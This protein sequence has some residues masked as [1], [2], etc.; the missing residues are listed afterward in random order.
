MKYSALRHSIILVLIALAIGACSSSKPIG[1]WR[2]DDF[3]G[4]LDNFLVI[5]VTSQSARRRVFEDN[6]VSGLAAL[7][8]NATPSYKLLASSLELDKEIVKKA[9]AGKDIGAVLVTR[10]AGFSEK[11]VYRQSSDLDENLSYFSI[12]GDGVK[13]I[14]HVVLTLETKVYDIASEALVWSMQSEVIDP[15]QS[16]Q[17]IQDQIKLTIDTLRKRGLVG[18]Q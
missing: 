1:E 16:R 13:Q 8:V 15:T 12:S 3:S 10:L 9:I 17:A 6:F 7:E 4:A 18:N 11:E 2:S 14:E 5:G